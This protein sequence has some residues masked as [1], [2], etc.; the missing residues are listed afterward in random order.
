MDFQ[1]NFI[2]KSIGIS[3]V[4][5]SL[6]ISIFLESFGW[7]STRVSSHSVLSVPLSL[8]HLVRLTERNV[9]KGSE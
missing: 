7:F 3:V 8:V 5:K 2:H 4:N 1:D 6:V 9:V